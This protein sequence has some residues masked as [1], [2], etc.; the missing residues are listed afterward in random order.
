M[1]ALFT[2]VANT[3]LVLTTHWAL[4]WTDFEK[5]RLSF[6]FPNTGVPGNPS[7]GNEAPA[8]CICLGIIGFCRGHVL[9]FLMARTDSWTKMKPFERENNRYCLVP[10]NTTIRKKKLL[11]GGLS[12]SCGRVSVDICVG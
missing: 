7:L 3:Y 4:C 9:I 5:N 11:F 1:A 8:H 2:H 12:Y 10:Q 6:L